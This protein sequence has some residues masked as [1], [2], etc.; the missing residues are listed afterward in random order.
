MICLPQSPKVL[1]LQMEFHFGCPYWSAMA[2]SQLSPTSTSQ[3]LALSPRLEC[4]DVISAH[5]NLYLPGSSSSPASAFKVAGITGTCHDSHLIFVFLVEMSFYHVGQADLELLSSNDLPAS[6]SQSAGITGLSHH[7]HPEY[8]FKVLITKSGESNFGRPRWV[9]QL[10]SGVQDQPGQY[11]ETLCQL[12]IQKLA[13][14]GGRPG[15][16]AH[17]C[18]L[19]ALRGQDK[20]INGAQEVKTSQGNKARSLST[21]NNNNKITVY[22]CKRTMQ[23]KAR[24]ELADY[25]AVSTT[26]LLGK[27]VIECTAMESRSAAQAAGV[28]WH[29]LGSLQPPPP[30][31]RQFFCLSL[32]NGISLLS[33]R[34][35][36]S[37][38]ISAHCNLC[39]PNSGNSPSSASQ[40]A[41]SI[42]VHHYARLIFVLLVETEFHHVGQLGLELLT[43]GDLPISA[44]QIAGITGMS[45]CTQ[46]HAWI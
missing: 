45:H 9:D 44:S 11:G 38:M 13:G 2:Q 46:P 10:N 43:S 18:D 34:L 15:T 26:D 29:D 5:C 14:L 6:A 25:E 33:S 39:L 17:A 42:G 24:L 28:Q 8:I 4:N 27:T 1:R 30:G 19:S 22:L 40:V 20:R 12:K 7:T 31:F 32:L 23:N 3:S 41:E 37:G 35:E 36:C 16:V 21:N